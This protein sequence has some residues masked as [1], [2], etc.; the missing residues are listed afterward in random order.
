SRPSSDGL[1]RPLAV[2]PEQIPDTA[3]PSHHALQSPDR[4]R[5]SIQHD[6][7]RQWSLKRKLWYSLALSEIAHTAAM[8]DRRRDTASGV[9]TSTASPLDT[10]FRYGDES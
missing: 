2:Y 6:C 4:S 10:T 7:C 9:P 1:P 5:Q 3:V 8:P